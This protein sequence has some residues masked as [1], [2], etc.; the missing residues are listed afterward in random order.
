M[1]G[2]KLW[3]ASERRKSAAQA[4]GV[5]VER[6]RKGYE[7]QLIRQ[8]AEEIIALVA[9]STAAAGAR[10]SASEVSDGCPE[11]EELPSGV[12]E[13]S[14]VLLARMGRRRTAYPLDMSLGELLHSDLAIDTRIE[15]YSSADRA[16]GSAVVSLAAAL[17]T[18]RSCLLLGEP[19][20]G[21][22]FVLYR[23][24]IACV[25][26][27]LVPLVLRAGDIDQVGTDPAWQ[28]LA[29]T[30][31]GSVV[32]LLDGLDE[33]LIA[34]SKASELP[35]LLTETLSAF[36]CLVTA[37][38]R[39]F[40]SSA[41]LHQADVVFDEIY[42]LKPWSVEGEFRDYVER[43]GLAGRS[44][45]LGM[46]KTVAGSEELT[47]L[48]SRPL[49]AR[50]LTFVG[51]EG[52]DQFPDSTSLYA[53]Y[54]AKLA[55]IADSAMQ[56][57]SYAV[58]T[59][60]LRLWQRFAWEVRR[61][62]S[63]AEA[64]MALS[65]L[66]GALSEFGTAGCVRSALDYILDRR[67]TAGREV[68]EFIHYSFYE[69]LMAGHVAGVLTSAADPGAIVEVCRADLTREIRHFLIGQLRAVSPVEV[70]RSLVE[71]YHH[72]RRSTAISESEIL[73][74]CN[75][76]AYLLSRTAEDSAPV[77][78][79]LLSDEDEL[80]LRISF[81]WALCHVG[82]LSGFREFYDDLQ[83]SESTRE[84]VRGYVLYYY[85]DLPP[86]TQPPY[87]DSP[88]YRPLSLTAARVLQLFNEPGFATKIY[89]A[90]QFIDIYA[91]ID[92]IR[93]RNLALLRADKVRLL[94]LIHGMAGSGIG[95]A[96]LA[97]LAARVSGLRLIEED[98]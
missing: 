39:D 51:E 37:R 11:A 16:G 8:V 7:T 3:A 19:G 18:G 94:A 26:A 6:F 48:V 58:S 92:V 20:A 17:R 70:S 84:L 31:T 86:G 10:P 72:A 9:E 43:L 13:L 89:P 69:Y 59:G 55:R 27:G 79:T 40:E 28:A 24:A 82:D 96:P 35:P 57:R 38:T 22:T 4:Q 83:S 67:E 76:I 2:T 91:L 80:F 47:R 49:H 14:T 34:W 98:E 73:I 62:G 68:G 81:L 64:A 53:E 36:P 88:P 12:R 90:R 50:M 29:R 78:R 23:T 60:V 87:R 93:V 41:L 52:L 56:R 1:Q 46:Y 74:V 33:A 75:L 30:P 25:A 15:H 32:V 95:E 44:V 65:P 97:E 54:V 21:K 85:G 66:E 71:A 63:H 5:S 61:H 45:D 77:L 42:R